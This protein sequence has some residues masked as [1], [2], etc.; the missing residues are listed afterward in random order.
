MLHLRFDP[1]NVNIAESRLP[2][3][4]LV[5]PVG[6][7]PGLAFSNDTGAT[8]TSLAIAYNGEQWR[9]GQS[10]RGSDRIDFQYSLNATDLTTGAYTDFNALDFV[11]PVAIGTVGALDGNASANR[12]ALSSTISGL[13][14]ANGATFWIRWTDFDVTGA[15]DGLAVDD[16]SLTP[17]FGGTDGENGGGTGGGNSAVPEPATLALFG[18]SLAGLGLSRRK[19]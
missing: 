6:S 19:P 8:I 18:I 16:F 10:G 3:L 17:T 13:S 9:L 12:T 2:A 15:D 7:G 11:S 14:I 4:S 5:E 1:C